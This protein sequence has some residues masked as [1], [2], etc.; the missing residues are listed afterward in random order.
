MMRRIWSG[1]YWWKTRTVDWAR[2]KFSNIRG[3]IPVQKITIFWPLQKSSK[4][5]MVFL[6]CVLL[7]NPN[8][9]RC[10]CIASIETIVWK[11]YPRLPNPPCLWTEWLYNISVWTPWVRC[12]KILFTVYHLRLNPRL[13]KGVRGSNFRQMSLMRKTRDLFFFSSFCF[14][15]F[16]S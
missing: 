9:T 13:C 3:S 4:G 5:R 1:S 7:D 11:S 15:Y 2:T 6:V 12:K 14:P 10:S 16:R 8:L